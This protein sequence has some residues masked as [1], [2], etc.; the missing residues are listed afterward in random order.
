VG[1][2]VLK[3]NSECKIIKAREQAELSGDQFHSF[4]NGQIFGRYILKLKEK[5]EKIN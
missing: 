3:D 1:A 2:G 5:V 4:R